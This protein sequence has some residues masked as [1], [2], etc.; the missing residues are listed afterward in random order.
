M[1]DHVHQDPDEERADK[2]AEWIH[3]LAVERDTYLAVLR[4]LHDTARAILTKTES[5]KPIT[6]QLAL[7]FRRAWK[8]AHDLIEIR[9]RHEKSIA[10][11]LAEMPPGKI[12]H[13]GGAEIV[14]FRDDPPKDEVRAHRIGELEEAALSARRL[15]AKPATSIEELAEL[16][17]RMARI[18]SGVRANR[19]AADNE[20]V[21]AELAQ[22]L[23]DA[24]ITIADLTRIYSGT[25]L[26]DPLVAP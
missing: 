26:P 13:L 3:P 12:E 7:R 4:G 25:K 17:G 15:G 9:D 11:A 21:R 24:R 10:E 1:E 16:V 2:A 14:D 8:S 23:G 18:E 5:G 19:I 20:H 6:A 22:V